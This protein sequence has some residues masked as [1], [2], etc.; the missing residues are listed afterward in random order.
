M[1][2]VLVANRG[3]IAVRVIRACKE[4][5]ISTVA[6]YSTA[7]KDALHV[8]LADEAICI[9]GPRSADSY[10]NMDSILTAAALTQAEAIHPGFG[11][12]SE[13]PRFAEECEKQGLIFI[14]PSSDVIRNMGDKAT[15]KKLMIEAGVNVVPGSE[16]IVSIDEG[17]II[18][19]E[20]GYPVLI[21]ATAGGGGR[22]MRIVQEPG[23]FR[24]M[25]KAA[26][27][28]A[29]NAF[30]DDGIYI[31]KYILNP[32]HIEFQILADQY[33]NV[34]HLGERDC[35]VQRR[36]QKMIEEAP[37]YS[38]SDDLR[39]RMGAASVRAAKHVNYVNAGTIE[40]VVV[41]EEYYFIEM[42][43]RIQVEHPVTEMV[44]GVDL[45]RQQLKIASGKKL[46]FT[47]EDIK[48]DGFAIELRINA[49]DPKLGFRPS[50]GEVT[51]LHIPGGF[52]VRFDSPIYQGYHIPPYYDSMIGKLIV[53]GPTRKATILKMRSALEELI[54]DGITD[55]TKLLYMILHNPEYVKGN[56]STGF[57]SKY[58]EQL[59]T[60]R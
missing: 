42:N 54:I 35:S 2:K 57:I 32:K 44:T 39:E 3:E 30:G 29:L 20:I 41:G 48:I 15:A 4:Q 56:F 5:N 38:I 31:E 19:E 11:F 26:A 36:N 21:K 49:E 16:G 47:Q 14:G 22:G 17:E 53:T 34:I 25:Y 8:K 27:T 18:A 1:R 59:L 37:C 6:V 46:S 12:L 13:N 60:Y 50:P 45:I 40:Y 52:G 58:L 33:G 9:G 43:T 7:D 10:L 23:E 55:N 28:E 24:D 51:A